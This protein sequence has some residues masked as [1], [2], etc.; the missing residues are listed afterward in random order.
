MMYFSIVQ[1]KGVHIIGPFRNVKDFLQWKKD[2]NVA[3]EYRIVSR[4]I[5]QDKVHVEE[6]TAL[7]SVLNGQ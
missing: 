4:Q 6:P 5:S 7:E 3:G 1:G 2:E